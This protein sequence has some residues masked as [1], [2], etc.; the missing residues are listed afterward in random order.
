MNS[1]KDSDSDNDNE[2]I[3]APDAVERIQ[4]VDNVDDTPLTEEQ[5]ISQAILNS[6]Q[7][8]KKVQKEQDDYE[9]SLLKQY[10]E[11]RLER[12]YIFKDLILALKKIATY[13]K[14]VAD[15]LGLVENIVE[16]YCLAYMEYCELDNETISKIFGELSKLRVNT[17]SVELLRGI[18][19]EE[20]K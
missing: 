10:T 19:R 6:I 18:I 1:S 4:M 14:N 9:E 11:T 17:K 12:E 15:V 3:R 2:Q 5:L 20:G 7:D 16:G 13:D 8:F